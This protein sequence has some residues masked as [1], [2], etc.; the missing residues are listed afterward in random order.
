[1]RSPLDTA[2]INSRQENGIFPRYQR[3]ESPLKTLFP[4]SHE[5]VTTI[6]TTIEENLHKTTTTTMT[7]TKMLIDITMKDTMM[8]GGVHQR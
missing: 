3:N 5:E 1:M 7:R 8:I 4:V 6:T 2:N